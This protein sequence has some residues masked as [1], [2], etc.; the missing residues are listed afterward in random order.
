MAMPSFLT[1]LRA[2]ARTLEPY[3]LG[4]LSVE[5]TLMQTLINSP[6]GEEPQKKIQRTSQEPEQQTTVRPRCSLLG[7]TPH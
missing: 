1:G 4:A 6:R 3:R 7:L 2:A 5:N